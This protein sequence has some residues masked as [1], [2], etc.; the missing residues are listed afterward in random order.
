[1][2]DNKEY[3]IL[4]EIDD[5]ILHRRMFPYYSFVYMAQLDNDYTGLISPEFHPELIGLK[6]DLSVNSVSIASII[7]ASV[8][9]LSEVISIDT[10]YFYDATNRVLYIHYKDDKTPH[11]FTD[12]EHKI[13]LVNGFYKTNKDKFSGSINGQQYYPR[14]KGTGKITDKK[15]NLFY[16]K[17]NYIS[18]T[19]D[20]NNED[21]RFVNYNIGRDVTEKKYGGLAKIKV[22]TGD[23]IDS[24]NYTTDF[25]TIYQGRIDKISEGKTLSL[26]LTDLRKQYDK[27]SPSTTFDLSGNGYNVSGLSED[28]INAQVWGYCYGVPTTCLNSDGDIEPGPTPPR[29]SNYE[30]LVCS[31]HRTIAVDAIDKVYINGTLQTT[32]SKSEGGE[33]EIE[34]IDNGYKVTI[35]IDYFESVNDSGTLS[36]VGMDK[37]TLDMT[38]Y[39]FGDG[40][41]YK[42]GLYIANAIL[43]D[44]YDIELTSTFYDDVADYL[45][46]ADDSYQLGYYLAEPKEVYKQLEDLSISMM[47]ALI[48][49]PDLKLKWTTDDQIETDIEIP[50]HKQLGSDYVPNIIQDPSEVLATLR[51]GYLKRWGTKS[52]EYILDDSNKADALT[53]FNSRKSKD[54][55]TLITLDTDVLNYITRLKVYTDESKDTVK[56]TTLL[57]EETL[58]M[59]AG[60]YFVSYVD[61]PNKNILGRTLQQVQSVTFDYE[62]FTV[63]LVGRIMFIG[64]ELLLADETGR[65]ITDENGSFIAV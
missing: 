46:Q 24:I 42:K 9:S 32:L 65:V 43:N 41:D 17:Q 27:T 57:T 49:T 21:F 6:T 29:I 19:I 63:D 33:L 23:D 48:I 28:P 55:N 16:G 58:S 25:A 18:N 47:G 50:I 31:N 14:L 3:L 59:T 39:V 51:V 44:N 1:M 37:L 20:I 53:N 52:Y 12:A 54:F 10:S 4:A 22:F 62:S 11:H 64:D 30:F 8:S 45:L 26:G 15:D 7:Y 56:M 60:D 36:Y 35:D 38:G 5:P 34:E 13:N 2:N 61:L 40:Y